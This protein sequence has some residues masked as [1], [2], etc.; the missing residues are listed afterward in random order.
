MFQTKIP[1]LARSTI[2][3]T[4]KAFDTDYPVDHV[5]GA[6]RTNHEDDTRHIHIT[7]ITNM[8]NW[9]LNTHGF[10]IL[11]A[12]TSS[13]TN[14]IFMDQEAYAEISTQEKVHQKYWY[15]IEALLHEKFPEYSRID[16]YDCT[17]MTHFYVTHLYLIVAHT[18]Q[19]K[20]SQ[21]RRREPDFP[22][23]VRLY[24]SDYEQ[25]AQR[26]HSDGSVGGAYGQ[27]EFSFPG[28]DD[29]WKDKHF[30]ILKSVTPTSHSIS[31]N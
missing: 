21:I 24:N 4:E 18:N 26:P 16:G 27:L 22:K 20:I 23:E 2:F 8:E 15:E 1:Y 25:P 11:K 5:P 10:C 14:S 28:Q 17:V 30:D 9:D 6:R 29:Y 31:S 12:Q 19:K 13:Q 3:E 7:N